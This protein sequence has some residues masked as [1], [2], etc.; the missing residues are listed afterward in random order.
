MDTISNQVG[1]GRRRRRAH[2]A[3]FKAQVVATCNAPGVLIAAVAMANGVNA[4]LRAAGSLLVSVA[5]RRRIGAGCEHRRADRLCALVI[6]ARRGRARGHPHRAAPR[7]D[8][9]Q[10][11][12]AVRRRIRLRGLD[13]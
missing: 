1:A 12:L 10:R 8:R 13:A 11:Q 5:W 7:R 2:S 4:N 6:A 9:D 3:E